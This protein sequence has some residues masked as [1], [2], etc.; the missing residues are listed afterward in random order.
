MSHAFC[1]ATF[2]AF[3]FAFCF[4]FCFSL[5]HAFSSAF[6]DQIIVVFLK[7]LAHC[8]PPLTFGVFT[9]VLFKLSMPCNGCE[10]VENFGDVFDFEIG[11]IVEFL[12][13]HFSEKNC[14]NFEIARESFDLFIAEPCQFEDFDFVVLKSRR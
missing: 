9:F 11:P 2:F 12:S 13:T 4:S 8:N 1:Q 3:G 10:Q 7:E 5:F 14:Q 6:F